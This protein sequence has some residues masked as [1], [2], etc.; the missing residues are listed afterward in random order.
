[1]YSLRRDEGQEGLDLLPIVA[2]D[3]AGESLLLD[4]ERGEFVSFLGPSGCGKT[5]LLNLIAG[6]ETPDSGTVR[7]GG[8]QAD[9]QNMVV[10]VLPN[11]LLTASVD[12]IFQF[13]V[14]G[15]A[16]GTTVN[17]VTTTRASTP[18]APKN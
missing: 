14:T 2:A 10:A 12:T 6:L 8:T 3:R 13:A 16:T 4:V 9:Y 18:T 5:T 1:M 17:G 11:V 15:I 7:I